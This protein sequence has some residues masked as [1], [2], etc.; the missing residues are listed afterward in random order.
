MAIIQ[1][2]GIRQQEGRTEE[3]KKTTTDMAAG[4]FDFDYVTCLSRV[5]ISAM[6]A[7]DVPKSEV[8]A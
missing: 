2:F 7:E 5:K 8:G 6:A 1:E 3:G 4:P